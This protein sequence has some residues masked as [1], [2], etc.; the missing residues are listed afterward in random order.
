MNFQIWITF[1]FIL[2][3]S[4]V[5]T[6]FCNKLQV[7]AKYKDTMRNTNQGLEGIRLSSCFQAKLIARSEHI[8]SKHLFS[9]MVFEGTML[10]AIQ[11][12][13]KEEGV[14]PQSNIPNRINDNT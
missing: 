11:T 13:C 8:T 10:G 3:L 12:E 7:N 4:G 6:L 2:I 14:K 5:L 9:L 1:N